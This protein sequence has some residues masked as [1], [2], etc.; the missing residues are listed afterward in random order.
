LSYAA[1]LEEPWEEY[2]INMG[3]MGIMSD[4]DHKKAKQAQKKAKQSKITPRKYG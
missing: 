4:I 2:I 3:I 1:F